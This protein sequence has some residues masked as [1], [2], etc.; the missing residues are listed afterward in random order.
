MNSCAHVHVKHVL[1]VGEQRE[2][3]FTQMFVE[4]FVVCCLLFACIVRRLV[5]ITLCS[6][7]PIFSMSFSF[8]L[9]LFR[10][11][12]KTENDWNNKRKNGVYLDQLVA[13]NVWNVLRRNGDQS[14]EFDNN[15]DE[16]RDKPIRSIFC[17]STAQE[18][19]RNFIVSC[20]DLNKRNVDVIH[21]LLSRTRLTSSLA[22]LSRVTTDNFFA[23]TYNCMNLKTRAN[24]R[25][26]RT[27]DILAS[28]R[29]ELWK[30]I[31][32]SSKTSLKISA[33]R[34]RM[35]L[36]GGRNFLSAFTCAWKSAETLSLVEV[37]EDFFSCSIIGYPRKVGVVEFVSSKGSSSGSSDRSDWSKV[38]SND[39]WGF[40]MAS[41]ILDCFAH[42]FFFVVTL[43]LIELSVRFEKI[44][45][46]LKS[47]PF[48]TLKSPDEQVNVVE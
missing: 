47:F 19:N 8:I 3:S 41:L 38:R 16:P 17:C 39:S 14:F 22:E 46:R 20:E 15:V 33:W 13:I 48:N 9:D 18:I 12:S 36:L 24:V 25:E 40:G 11:E 21:S 29:H 45:I 34:W 5:Q 2:S 28:R 35:V 26:K 1:I 42:C 27:S 23:F 32:C 4:V 7:I 6:L 31:F 44:N 43:A 30:I 10:T 37:C